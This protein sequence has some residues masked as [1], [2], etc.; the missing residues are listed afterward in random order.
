[1]SITCSGPSKAPRELTVSRQTPTAGESAWITRSASSRALKR[2][3]FSR[4]MVMPLSS[5]NG[6]ARLRMS[7]ISLGAGLKSPQSMT[8]RR[9]GEAK[10]SAI[11]P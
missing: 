6:T 5:K 7:R 11:S 4:A 9:I 8:A 3:W 2:S 1:M 10:N